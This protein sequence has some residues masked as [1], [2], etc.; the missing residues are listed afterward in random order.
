MIRAIEAAIGRTRTVIIAF[1]V[2][3][4]AGVLSYQGMP[5][6]NE[7]EIAFP[8][9]NVVVALEGVSPEDSERLLVRP[10]EQELRTLEG[11]KEMVASAAEGRATISLEFEPDVDVDIALQEVRER[12]DL[13]QPKLPQDAEE[14]RVNEVK[15]SRFDPMMVMNIGGNVPERVLVAIA[16]D[17]KTRIESLKGVLELNIVG[18]REE[19]LEV[20][21]DPLRMESYGLSP[22]DVL[23]FVQRNNRLVAAGALQG[24]QGRFAVKVPGVIESPV[25]SSTPTPRNRANARRHASRIFLR[26][27]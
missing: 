9:I 22:G 18:A 16:R 25:M 5:K 26:A 15:F 3:M 23:N 4:I 17:L 19:V 12:V 27:M 11:I 13:A 20:V 7:P 10:L 2:V 24:E 21:V 1:L 8:Y 14:P 6:E